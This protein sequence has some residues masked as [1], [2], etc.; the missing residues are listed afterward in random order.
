MPVLCLQEDRNIYI[1]HVPLFLQTIMPTCLP[2]PTP[3]APACGGGEGRLPSLGGGQGRGGGGGGGNHSASPAWEERRG[4]KRRETTTMP[5][6]CPMP[7]SLAPLS[8]GRR[9]GGGEEPSLYLSLYI[10]ISIF[11]FPSFSSF[12]CHIFIT[13]SLFLWFFI[14][15]FSFLFP[16]SFPLSLYFFILYSSFIQTRTRGAVACGRKPLPK[17]ETD[18]SGYTT[19]TSSYYGRAGQGMKNNVTCLPQKQNRHGSMD[20][21][22]YPLPASACCSILPTPACHPHAWLPMPACEPTYT[23][24]LP[25]NPSTARSFYLPTSLSCHLPATYLVTHYLPN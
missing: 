21:P 10:Y 1:P 20:R 13:F 5:L 12:H 22:W 16:L 3:P 7:S 18:Y 14:P 25:W 8:L 24:C 19:A 17:Y 23:L 2:V 11:L 6:L 15:S 4:G 9:G